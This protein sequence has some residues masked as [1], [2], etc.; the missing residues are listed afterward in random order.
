MNEE[1]ELERGPA[2][3][4]NFQV[5]KFVYEDA[6]WQSVEQC[7]QAVKFQDPIR[8]RIRLTLPGS[9]TDHDYGIDVW[10]IG[11]EYGEFRRK[12][13]DSVR[14]EIMYQINHAKYLQNPKLQEQL[15]STGKRLIW[16]KPSTA[17]WQVWNSLIQMQIRKEITEDKLKDGPLGGEGLKEALRE[18][19]QILYQYGLVDSMEHV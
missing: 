10:R 4:D 13:W 12:D 1:G 9:Q 19:L 14:L 16:G 5:V 2:C 6:E 17:N 8:E 3:T 11:R 7:F 18:Q 15:L